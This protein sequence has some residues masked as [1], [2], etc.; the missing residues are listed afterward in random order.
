MCSA[1]MQTRRALA[2]INKAVDGR[3]LD[4]DEAAVFS[5]YTGRPY[6]HRPDGYLQL[7]ILVGRQR[8]AGT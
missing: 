2:L 5:R 8:S 7:V 1:W 4:D 6:V 3:P